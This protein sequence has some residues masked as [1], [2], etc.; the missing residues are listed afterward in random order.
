MVAGVLARLT[1]F[2]IR[3]RLCVICVWTCFVAAGAVGALDLSSCLESGFSLPGTDSA[4]ISELLATHYPESAGS[5][6]VIVT[7]GEQPLASAR[8]AAVPLARPAPAH[9]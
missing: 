9:A 5:S 6:F 4:R 2:S 3:H 1:G 7:G 8:A